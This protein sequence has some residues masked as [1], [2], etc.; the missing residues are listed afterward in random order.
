MDPNK[1]ADLLK[2]YM[3]NDLSEEERL[4]VDAWIDRRQKTE[5][6][7]QEDFVLKKQ[8]KKKIDKQIQLNRYKRI[9]A[10]ASIS[11]VCFAL[12]FTG[13]NYWLSDIKQNDAKEFVISAPKNQK[14][15]IRMGD[16]SVIILNEESKCS[17]SKNFGL[18]ERKVTLLEG[19]AYFDVAANRHKPFV[20][21]TKQSQTMVL[22]TAFNINTKASMETVTLRKGKVA[23]TVKAPEKR[24]KPLY[25]NP[26]E[27]VLIMNDQAPIK[28]P[29]DALLASNWNRI[30]FEDQTIVEAVVKL[31]QVYG[32]QI[33]IKN[34]K[35]NHVRF[36]ASFN[37]SDKP[38]DIIYEL[39]KANNFQYTWNEHQEVTLY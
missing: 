13:I 29:V 5:R 37:L 31:A 2:K 4:H 24:T 39:A 36:S 27:Q 3:N 28:Q 1:I 26:N 12:C 20:V 30:Y 6:Y 18:K 21:E 35:L 14:I 19:E 15:R 16:G 9:A 38:V 10:K 34:K 17:Y 32:I 22:G 23:V 11:V 33:V 25:L 8:V 7:D